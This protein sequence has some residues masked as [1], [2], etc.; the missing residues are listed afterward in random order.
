M[1]ELERLKTEPVEPR[2]LQRTLNQ[3]DAYLVRSLQSNSGLASQL[4]YYESVAGDWR[5]ILSSHDRMAKVTPEDIRETAKKYFVKT[6]RV[7]ATLVKKK[8]GEKEK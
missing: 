1:A 3:L 4:A 8:K 7:T 5:Y 2:E 6:N